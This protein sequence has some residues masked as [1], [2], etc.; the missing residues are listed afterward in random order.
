MKKIGSF[1]KKHK[2]LTILCVLVIFLWL[3]MCVV[4]EI[5]RLI[6]GPYDSDIESM[7]MGRKVLELFDQRDKEG[8]KNLFSKKIQEYEDLD[9]QIDAAFELF[10]GN[11]EEY[12][13]GTDYL[14]GVS[15]AQ[16]WKNHRIFKFRMNAT[17][18][19][20]VTTADKTY[21]FNYSYYF[22]YERD[23]DWEGMMYIKI[24]NGE[25]EVEIGRHYNLRE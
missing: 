12:P 25:Q 20:I 22:S 4:P 11:I 8:L 21:D 24:R 9:P 17:I 2:R 23:E 1:L 19:D 16:I 5:L 18:D 15:G 13:Y 14:G 10:E 7:K 3:Y 6:F